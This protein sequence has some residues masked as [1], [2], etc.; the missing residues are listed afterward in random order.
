MSNVGGIYAITNTLNGKSYIGSAINI[1]VRWNQHK[2]S[3][4]NRK[5]TSK[6]LQCAWDKYGEKEFEFSILEIVENKIE[7]IAREQHWI[8]HLNTVKNGYN[9]RLIASSQLG[10]KHS[11]QTKLK[12]SA[13]HLGSKRNA[14][15]KEKMSK[16]QI[17]KVISSETKK[18]IG[19][20][21]RGKKR[22]EEVKSK[23][24]KAKIGTK[25]SAETILKLANN[26][27]GKSHSD[28]AKNKIS[29]S[30]KARYKYLHENNP[31]KLKQSREHIEKREKARLA[32]LL[33]KKEERLQ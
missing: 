15:T 18:K 27:K 26:F 17:G 3:L 23:M 16:L 9:I 14:E 32:T 11:E 30:M 20:K 31:A 7:L 29:E 2:Y 12:M 6:H 13:S 22:S 33:R 5:N 10:M 8:D 24:R 25:H 28:E 21:N 4:R 19:D 1:R